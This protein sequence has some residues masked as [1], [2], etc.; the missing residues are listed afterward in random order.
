MSGKLSGSWEN[1]NLLLGMGCTEVNKYFI[2]TAL[3]SN[4]LIIQKELL[5][6]CLFACFACLLNIYYSLE[7]TL[8]LAKVEGKKRRE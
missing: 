5:G 7:M 2:G 6:V 1:L 3:K 4:A 8:M